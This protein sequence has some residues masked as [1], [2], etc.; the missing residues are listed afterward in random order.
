MTRYAL[1]A[2]LLLALAT[3]GAEPGRTGVEMSLALEP[4]TVLPGLPV[5]FRVTMTNRS[6]HRI[7]VPANVHLRV[8]PAEG[9]AFTAR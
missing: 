6:S 8:T 9:E 5:S 3:T 4:A 1:I 2:S 7:V